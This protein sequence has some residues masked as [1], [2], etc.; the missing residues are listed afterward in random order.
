Y[1]GRHYYYHRDI[2]PQ[3]DICYPKDWSVDPSRSSRVQVH[4]V[5]VR[6]EQLEVI[7]EV[8]A[9]LA[10]EDQMKF[11]IN[12]VDDGNERWQAWLELGSPQNLANKVNF[13][14]EI[15]DKELFLKVHD[16]MTL[17][18][19]HKYFKRD[20]YL[21]DAD[22]RPV[23]YFYFPHDT[24]SRASYYN[25]GLKELLERSKKLARDA[26]LK[27]IKFI[28]VTSGSMQRNELP[29]AMPT[30]WKPRDKTRPWLGGAYVDKILFQDYVPRLSKMG[31]EGLSAYIYHS[32]YDQYNRSYA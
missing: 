15:P 13:P 23:V 7:L 24:E 27:G 29:Y 19:I 30:D 32:F 12:W 5:E 1:F 18:W 20:D 16:K 8:N 6:T 25:V 2:A 4:G 31:F 9:Q 3:E 22:G 11:A 17:L 10:K 28:A 21:K 26:G 14:G